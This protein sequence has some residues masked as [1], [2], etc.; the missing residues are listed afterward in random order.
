[1]VIFAFGVISQLDASCAM[2]AV[3][4]WKWYYHAAD[5]SNGLV[6]EPPVRIYQGRC[7]RAALETLNTACSLP[8]IGR[9]VGTVSEAEPEVAKEEAGQTTIRLHLIAKQD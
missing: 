2:H 6:P 5:L 8:G 3:Y 4:Q 7:V 1:M 9:S